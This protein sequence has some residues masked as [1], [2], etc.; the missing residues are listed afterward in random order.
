MARKRMFSPDVVNQDDFL[1]MP[2]DS[3]LLYF[4]LGL[5]ADD[6]G[7]VSPKKVMRMV[8]SADDN[9]KLLIAKGFL[10]PFESGVVVVRHWKQ[11][12]FIRK[13]RYIPT[14]F[15]SEFKQLNVSSNMYR[16]SPE[17]CL[18]NQNPLFGQP[19]VNL[20]REE[21]RKNGEKGNNEVEEEKQKIRD[22]LNNK[23]SEKIEKEE[24]KQEE[25][26]KIEP[27]DKNYYEKFKIN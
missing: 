23:Q 25:E 21:E 27:L 14:T 19:A 1:D 5:S 9:L 10:I 6:D 18:V 8:N 13:D 16:L 3:Q 22:L 7:F 20:V 26:M 15:Q 11:N 17:M 12:N 4:H 24:E 2:V